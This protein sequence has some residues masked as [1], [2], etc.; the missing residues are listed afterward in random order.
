MT[1][2]LLPIYI[3]VYICIY[4]SL[5]VHISFVRSIAMDSWTEQQL[6]CMKL[7]GN[8]ACNTYIQQKSN[9]TINSRTP[10]KQKYDNPHAQLYKEILKA[11]VEGRPEPTS[12]PPPKQQSSSSSMMN[13]QMNSIS[14]NSAMNGHGNV[15]MNQDPNGMERLLGET[16]AQ[17]VARQTR[18]R[19]EAKARMVSKFGNGGLSNSS[20]GNNGSRMQG[21]GSDSRYN[22]N[23]GGYGN[24]NNTNDFDVSSLVTGLGSVFGSAMNTAKSLADEQTIQAVKSTGASFWGG[25]TSTVSTVAS[26]ITS[27]QDDTDGLA[28]LQRQIA[29][30]KSSQPSGSKYGGFGSDSVFTSTSSMSGTPSRGVNNYSSSTATTPSSSSSSSFGNNNNMGL[31]Q[32][33]QGLPGEDRNGIERLTG[34]S[35]EQ[36][37]IRQ[38]RLRDE[39]KARM[40]AKFGNNGLSSAS[41]STPNKM[42][43]SSPPI[44]SSANFYPNSA[45]MTTSAST[46]LRSAP[47]SGN[48]PR[49]KTPP[50]PKLMNSNDFFSSFG[51]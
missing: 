9:G 28:E 44:P 4:S 23:T 3:S 38:T 35:D 42:I 32:E 15:G 2:R 49:S 31:L 12:L 6:K 18:L 48:A 27:P 5:G 47:T 20:A 17:Y 34:E 43:S 16:D 1:F 37:V 46:G 26:S 51:S 39:A 50:P 14:S 24:S 41:S 25:L 21:I 33:A 8:E 19:E 13:S 40:A 36:Y 29:S 45:T 10:I 7:G 30:Q 11:R 22:P